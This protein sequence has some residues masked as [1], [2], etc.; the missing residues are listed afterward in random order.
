MIMIVDIIIIPL[1]LPGKRYSGRDYK[2][3]KAVFWL[4]IFTF[5]SVTEREGALFRAKAKDK[6]NTIL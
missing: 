3:G 2:K 5:Q 4:V 1:Q 6:A